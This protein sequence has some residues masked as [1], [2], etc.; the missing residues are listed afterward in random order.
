MGGVDRQDQQLVCFP[1]MRKFMKGNV[2]KKSI[3][4]FRLDVAEEL[5]AKV[6]LPNYEVSGRPSHG[7]TPVRL[8]AKNWGHFPDHIP[9]TAKKQYP[10]KRCHVCFKNN[11]RSEPTWQ[12]NQCQVPLHLPECLEKYHTLTDY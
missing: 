5:L 12:C 6:T 3:T 7:D 10:T 4:S 11:V 8:Q 9:P 1:V 2:K